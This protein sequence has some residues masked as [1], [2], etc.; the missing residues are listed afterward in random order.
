MR[1]AAFTDLT[2]PDGVTIVERPD[3]EPGPGEA[4]VDVEACA[5][6]RHDL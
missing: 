5:I 3:P 6:N 4:V 2:G 1:V